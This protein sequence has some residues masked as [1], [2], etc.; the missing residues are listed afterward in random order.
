MKNKY[1]R[2]VIVYGDYFWD[3][4]NI[5]SEETQSKIDWVIGLVRSLHVVPAKFLKHIEDT[6][7]L[8][9]MRI[10]VSNNIYRIF[11]CFDSGRLVIL[12]NGFQKKTEKTPKQEIEK[13][14]RLKQEYYESKKT[15]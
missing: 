2:D 4:Y 10:K 14:K 9:E 8:Y 6:E 15:K 5:Q 13:A 1:L 11:C 3:F 12:F 7:G